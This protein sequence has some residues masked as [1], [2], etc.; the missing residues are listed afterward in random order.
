MNREIGI[1][2]GFVNYHKGHFGDNDLLIYIG[3]EDD[4]EYLEHLRQLDKE[5]RDAYDD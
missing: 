2:T 5:H 1:L 3:A 4:P